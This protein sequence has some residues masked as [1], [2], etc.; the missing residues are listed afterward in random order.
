MLSQYK[1][2]QPG[3]DPT[4]QAFLWTQDILHMQEP[5]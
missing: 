1:K 4:V 3:Q 5:S 2:T